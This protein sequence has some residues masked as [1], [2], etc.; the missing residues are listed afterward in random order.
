MSD[1]L[2]CRE[3]ML[4]EHPVIQDSSLKIMA[5]AIRVVKSIST[6][7]EGTQA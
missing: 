3:G 1:Y 4:H 5:L 6:T 7:R 2:G